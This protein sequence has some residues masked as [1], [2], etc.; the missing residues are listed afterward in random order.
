[1]Q[2]LTTTTQLQNDQIFD[3]YSQS[4]D[5]MLE[6]NPAYQELQ[7]LFKSQLQKLSIDRSK[8]I[9]VLDIGGGTGNFS[10]LVKEIFPNAQI[11]LLEPNRGMIDRAKTK[12][13]SRSMDYDTTAFEKWDSSIKYDLVICIHALYLM[14]NPKLLIPKIAGH[15]APGGNAIICDIGKPINVLN[16]S[17]YLFRKLIVKYSLEE[18]LAYFRKGKQIT[19]ANKKISALQRK[20][21]PWKHNLSQF[22]LYFSQY[23][24]VDEGFSCYRGYS[25]FIRC[26]K[27]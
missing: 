21:N 14:P 18:T 7:M 25:N 1:M 3:D 13:P 10:V 2:T 26:V 8:A 11:T 15:L 22:K 9:K 4:Y 20:K 16:W 12:L 6:L 19:K 23:L 27:G 17:I 24:I 5:M